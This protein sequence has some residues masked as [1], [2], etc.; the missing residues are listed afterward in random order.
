MQNLDFIACLKTISITFRK[1][2]KSR[3]AS[4]LRNQDPKVMIHMVSML[5]IPQ[6]L[7]G[8]RSSQ[9]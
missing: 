2:Q 1:T 8:Q 4:T 7:S 3:L 5:K 9:C 6:S